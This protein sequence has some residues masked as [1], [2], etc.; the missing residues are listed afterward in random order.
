MRS[1]LE[2]L[3]PPKVRTPLLDAEE[4]NI[5]TNGSEKQ[6]YDIAFQEST[7]QEIL[8]YLAE[9]DPS[10]KVRKAVAQNPSTPL[11]AAPILSKDRSGDVRFYL[12]KRLVK[13]LPSLEDEQYSQLYAYAVQALG[14]LALDEI[15]KVRKALSETLKDYART[16]PQVALTLAKDLEREVSEPILRFCTALSDDALIDV[17]KTHPAHWAANAVAQR[18]TLSGRVSKAVIES[19]N[20]TAGKYLLQ[21][22]GAEIPDDLLDA[23]VDRAKEFP[24]WHKPIALRIPLPPLMAR[25]LAAYVDKSV[26]KILVERSDLDDETINDVAVIIQRR[27]EYEDNFKK[28]AKKVDALERAQ[29]LYV[30]GELTEEMLSDAAAMRDRKFVLAGMALLLKT[31]FPTVEK[32]FDVKAPKAICAL[33]WKAGLSMRFSLHVQQVLAHI[34]P[35]QLVYPRGGQDYPLSEADMQ[36]QLDIIGIE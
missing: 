20:P 19:G 10:V 30:N 21:N 13:I 9:N 34:P 15:L 18:K 25:K 33:C 23:I 7:S 2:K 6:R 28:E 36:W 8:Y 35:A 29:R 31:N 22:P 1:F 14:D 17:L 32:V 12:A 16:P 5:A 11:Q 24:E 3:F 27:I 26:R 4:K